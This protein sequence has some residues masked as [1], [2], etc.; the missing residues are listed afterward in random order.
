[1]P[2]STALAVAAGDVR[3][4]EKLEPAPE[5]VSAAAEAT[6]A[7]ALKNL[8]IGISPLVDTGIFLVWY[9]VSFIV[10]FR[11]ENV[12]RNMM[13]NRKKMNSGILKCRCDILVFDR[14][15]FKL[16]KTCV[17]LLNGEGVVSGY[18]VVF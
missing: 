1:M 3:T 4:A 17:D 18:A 14:E 9:P 6:A 2:S 8:F 13:K 5:T 15:V 16:D 12:N 10:T 11:A 7:I